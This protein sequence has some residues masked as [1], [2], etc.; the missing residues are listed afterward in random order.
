MSTLWHH[1]LLVS[2]PSFPTHS[3]LLFGCS[4]MGVGGR[5]VISALHWA[6]FLSPLR[7]P[8]APARVPAT[9]LP[10]PGQ[11]L[12]PTFFR[13]LFPDPSER[14]IYGLSSYFNKKGAGRAGG[15]TTRRRRRS[16]QFFWSSSLPVDHFL[17]ASPPRSARARLLSVSL[18]EEMERR[19]QLISG[20]V[21]TSVR[22][23]AGS[24]ASDITCMCEWVSCDS[25]KEWNEK[26]ESEASKATE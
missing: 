11:P 13:P 23:S 5:D 1:P 25:R 14:L 16:A 18:R 26:E 4:S 9:F 17:P 6:L 2:P 10:A 7:R 19:Y 8:P 15:R 24:S 21:T 12:L 20:S 3:F 22:P